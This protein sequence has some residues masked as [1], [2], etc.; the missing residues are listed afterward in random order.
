MPIQKNISGNFNLGTE[1][2]VKVDPTKCKGQ[3]F[4]KPQDF[5]LYLSD[6]RSH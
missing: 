1:W 4:V 2:D 3:V 5:I 6:P